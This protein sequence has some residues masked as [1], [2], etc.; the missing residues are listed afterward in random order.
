MRNED[1]L[2]ERAAEKP[3]GGWGSWGRNLIFDPETG[4]DRSI[5]DGAWILLIGTYGWLGY[6]AQF[7]LMTL[8]VI[9]IALGRRKVPIA[10][11]MWSWRG[12]NT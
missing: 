8:P 12:P 4:Q 10:P 11:A 1:A 3:W 5:V 9:L 2:S 6:L 7:G